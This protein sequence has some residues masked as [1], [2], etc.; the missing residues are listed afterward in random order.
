MVVLGAF[1][2]SLVT[3]YIMKKRELKKTWQQQLE[4]NYDVVAN[5]GAINRS[6]DIEENV[7]YGP[8]RKYSME[9][10]SAYGTTKST[11]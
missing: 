4:S 5:L 6:F 8:L 9:E 10:N 11:K 2:G 7:A 1:I 3:H